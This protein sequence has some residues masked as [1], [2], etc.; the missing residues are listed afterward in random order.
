MAV[1]TAT[2]SKWA[3]K[4]F[5]AR[6]ARLVHSRTLCLPALA[7]SQARRK[8]RV[9]LLICLPDS[10]PASD[11]LPQKETSPLGAR[12]R[13]CG[14]ARIWYGFWV[15]MAVARGS[16]RTDVQGVDHDLRSRR[17]KEV[18][19]LELCALAD[20]S[21][22]CGAVQGA[23]CTLLSY[24]YH[25]TRRRCPDDIAG[26]ALW[27]EPHGR[28]R[29]KRLG[30]SHDGAVPGSNSKREQLCTDATPSAA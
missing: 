26:Y 21:G 19:L 12:R 11:A 16:A 7:R 20:G 22:A 6:A 1:K 8:W 3:K 13:H 9:A 27:A 5:K 18:G 14:S 30:I 15:W 24:S 4:D 2:A 25:H 29:W 17:W 10:Q 23:A 28:G